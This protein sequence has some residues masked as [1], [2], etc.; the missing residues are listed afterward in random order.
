M[1]NKIKI[2]FWYWD[3]SA[4][5]FLLYPFLLVKYSWMLCRCVYEHTMQISSSKVRSRGKGWSL[6]QWIYVK[7]GKSSNLSKV[8][9]TVMNRQGNFADMI[10]VTHMYSLNYLDSYTTKNTQRKRT[11]LPLINIRKEFIHQDFHHPTQ[12]QI[13]ITLQ[14]RILEKLIHPLCSIICRN[15]GE[16]HMLS[17]GPNPHLKKCITGVLLPHKWNQNKY[18]VFTFILNVTWNEISSQNIYRFT[19]PLQLP[20]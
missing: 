4:C 19:F 18:W 9:K 2:I 1:S 13:T 7:I 15:V 3:M 12:R 8:S 20:W 6:I 17:V 10:K 16:Q 11:Y 5:I 14:V